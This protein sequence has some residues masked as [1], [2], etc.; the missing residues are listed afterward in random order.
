[1]AT[2]QERAE[3]HNRINI[4]KSYGKSQKRLSN[5]KIDYHFLNLIVFFLYLIVF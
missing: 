2:Q 1:M 3:L 4:L 5:F